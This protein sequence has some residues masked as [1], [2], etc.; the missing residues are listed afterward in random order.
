[1]REEFVWLDTYCRAPNDDPLRQFTYQLD[2]AEPVRIG[3]ELCRIGRPRQDWV[4]RSKEN[5]HCKFR[6]AEYDGD[7]TQNAAILRAAIQSKSP[8][9][10]LTFGAD[11]LGT[12]WHKK[13]REEPISVEVEF[14]S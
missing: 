3:V 6:D 10:H 7:P 14:S 12:G 5:I 11:G 4:Y 2:S 9:K 1:M 13:S 8:P